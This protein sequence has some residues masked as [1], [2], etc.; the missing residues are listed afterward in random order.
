MVSNIFYKC[1][2]ANLDNNIPQISEKC[3]GN[4]LRYQC[5]VF[6]AFNILIHY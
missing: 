2:T 5:T 4:V 1:K 6:I 3:I